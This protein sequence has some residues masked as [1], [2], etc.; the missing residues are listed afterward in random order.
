MIARRG[1]FH[2]D[3]AVDAKKNHSVRGALEEKEQIAGDG[4]AK[5]TPQYIAPP[6]LKEHG[7]TCRSRVIVRMGDGWMRYTG[8][9]E[10][11][12]SVA[13]RQDSGRPDRL[14]GPGEGGRSA[15]VA[16]LGVIAMRLGR[17]LEWDPQKERFIGDAE[18]QRHVARP[19]RKPYDYDMV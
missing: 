3:Y 8:G 18:A 4:H 11:G 13:Q 14:W 7:F 16:H 19:M 2:V 15:T 6:V 10:T 9:P 12:H 5:D 17:K 1:T